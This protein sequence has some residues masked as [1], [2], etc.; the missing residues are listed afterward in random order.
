MEGLDC[1]IFPVLQPTECSA[2]VHAECSANVHFL[3]LFIYLFN[4]SDHSMK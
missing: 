2:N 1:L 4:L 3:Y